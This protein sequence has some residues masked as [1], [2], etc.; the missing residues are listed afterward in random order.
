MQYVK[1]EG[2]ER[3]WFAVTE[4]GRPARQQRKPYT[5]CFYAMAMSELHRANGEHKYQVTGNL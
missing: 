4:D 2:R 1:E 5:E 3:C